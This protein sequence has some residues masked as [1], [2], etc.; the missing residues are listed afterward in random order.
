MK[1]FQFYVHCFLCLMLKCQY[2]ACR[3]FFCITFLRRC[4]M[5]RAS[6]LRLAIVVCFATLAVMN[7][8]LS[9]PIVLG[10]TALA[11][12][13]VCFRCMSRY[14][15]CTKNA[16]LLFVKSFPFTGSSVVDL[17]LERGFTSSQGFL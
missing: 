13:L 16:L 17:R 11:P 2:P 7:L 9:P 6:S 1:V 12:L 15:S 3:S 5:Y 4:G 14:T 8:D 10:I